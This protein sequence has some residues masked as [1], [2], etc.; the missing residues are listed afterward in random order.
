[1]DSL[2]VIGG[3]RK[4]NIGDKKE[5]HWFQRGLIVKINLETGDSETCVEYTTPPEA[6]A[7]DEDPSIL[8][9]AGA[10]QGGKLY[11]CTQTEILIYEMPS[12]RQERYLSLPCFNDLHH[13]CPTAK[14]TLLVANTGLDMVVE[15]TLDGEVIREWGALGGHPWERFS[16]M[17]DYR[18]VITTKPH[19]S[20]PNYVFQIDEDIW[21]T[22]FEQ[23]DIVC[24]TQPELRVE[25]GI[26]RP[27][28]GIVHKGYVYCTTVNGHIIVANLKNRM[29]EADINLNDI[30]DTDG[31]SLGWC[32][33][34]KV[35]DERYVIVGF[36]RLRPTKWREN[37]RWV[38]RRF[39]MDAGTMPTRVAL[40]DLYLRKL[41]CEQ[42]VEQQNLGAVFS[43]HTLD[44]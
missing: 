19:Q 41:C 12:F 39:G 37:I 28:D 6:C 36:S 38:K 42:S 5:W 29:V 23:R 14:G 2:Y 44:G 30:T 17:V 31:R 8:F 16:R 11:V 10:I 25:I 43:I 35:L 22:R 3:E 13:V 7:A 24:L 34:L 1:M 15:T 4:T 26:E 27:H 21:V 32:R 9:K 20:H 33:G 18:K 40:Y